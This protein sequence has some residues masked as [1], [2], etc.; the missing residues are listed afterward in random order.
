M[1]IQRTDTRRRR[2]RRIAA[3]ASAGIVLALLAGAAVSLVRRPPGIDGSAIWSGRVARGEF[4]HEV[5]GVG[6]LHAPEVRAVTN[7]SEGVVERVRVLAGQIVEPDDVLA[8]LSSPSLLQELAKAKSELATAEI[9]EALRKAEAEDSYLDLLV[10]LAAAEADYTTAR[11]E[12]EI[13]QRLVQQGATSALE[14]QRALVRAEQLKKNLEAVQAQVARYPETSA[15]RDA[16]AAARLEQMRRDVARLEEQVDDLNVRAGLAGVVQEMKVEEGQRLV[17]G[18]EVARIVNPRILIARVRVSERD[19]AFVEPGQ[20]TRLEMGRL[21]VNG[22]VTRVEPT[23]RDR[24]VTVDIALVDA[25]TPGLRPDLSVTARIEI[26]RA[27]DTLILDRP[28]GLRDDARSAELFVLD[29][30]GGR[31]RRVDV[32]LGRISPRQIEIK[33]GLDVGDRVV[34][35]DMSEWL[36]EREV[37]IR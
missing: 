33:N 19:A 27:P 11:I 16:A 3:L 2:Y 14:A 32:A 9:E 26:D 8:E 6:T 20:P 36:E 34:L 4:V 13:Q 15:A 10:A 37:R 21:T 30:G 1:D 35:A 5:T 22:K 7:R 25:S 29:G 31:A 12:T 17:M 28:A 24:L 23:V 18:S